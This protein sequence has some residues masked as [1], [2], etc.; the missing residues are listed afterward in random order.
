MTNRPRSFI[1]QR[2]IYGQPMAQIV[3]DDPRV[4]SLEIKPLREVRLEPSD[5]RSLRQLAIDYP[6]PT[7]QEVT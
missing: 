7:E 5:A 2:N 1:W 4:G 3:Y 6:R